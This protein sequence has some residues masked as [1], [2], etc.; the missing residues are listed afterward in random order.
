G[1]VDSDLLSI[2]HLAL[3]ELNVAHNSLVDI[4]PLYHLNGDLATLDISYNSIC[5]DGVDYDDG[6]ALYDFFPE[7]DA[8]SNPP[9][10]T[11]SSQDTSSCGFCSSSE[12]AGDGA[13][14]GAGDPVIHCSDTSSAASLSSNT[15]CRK[16]WDWTETVEGADDGSGGVTTT[17]TT[18]HEQWSVECNLY[19]YKVDNGDEASSSC[20][21]YLDESD[22]YTPPDTF[23][24]CVESSMDNLN[25][26]CSD[27]TGSDISCIEGWYSIMSTDEFCIYECPSQ[28]N[29][30][31][32]LPCGG[33]EYGTCDVASHVCTCENSYTGDSCQYVN[34]TSS[35]LELSIC[36][37]DEIDCSGSD[38]H[39]TLSVLSSVT[40]LDLSDVSLVSEDDEYSIS[41][42]LD[43]LRFATSL[44]ELDL[45]VSEFTVGLTYDLS[46]LSELSSL[47]TLNLSGNDMSSTAE[48][49]CESNL[50]ALPSSLTTLILDNVGLEE[51]DADFSGFS[52]LA[53]L[54]VRDN[55]TFNP[56]DDEEFTASSR[57]PTSLQNL[58]IGGCSEISDISF[59]PT[60]LTT[61]VADGCSLDETTDF[62]AF[63]SLTTLGVSDNLDYDV[64]NEVCLPESV[65]SFYAANTS[66]SQIDEISIM[67]PNVVNLD[68]SDNSIS[69]PS[70]LFSLSSTLT[71]LDLSGNNICGISDVED[72]NTFVDAFSSL[73]TNAFSVF[74]N[75]KCLC[76]D[77]T[78]S[79]ISLSSNIVCSEIWTDEYSATCCSSCYTDV[80]SSSLSC[81]LIDDE[82][83]DLY[84]TCSDLSLS[85]TNQK[86][87]GIGSD[88]SI[89]DIS[90]VCSEGWYGDDCLSECPVDEYGYECGNADG[91]DNNPCDSETHTCT[92]SS[93]SSSLL[94]TGDLCEIESG[95]TLLSSLGMDVALVEAIC[96]SMYVDD[97][98]VQSLCSSS[99]AE[100]ILSSLTVDDLSTITSLT[101]PTTVSSLSGLE[102]AEHLEILSFAQGNILISDLSPIAS[103]S[104]L[105][106]LELDSLENMDVSL[107]STLTDDVGALKMDLESD[108]SRWNGT[109]ESYC[110]GLCSLRKLRI[111]GLDNDVGVDSSSHSA[112][113]SFVKVEASSFILDSSFT[114][115]LNNL[116][117]CSGQCVSSD[118]DGTK[119]YPLS[120]TLT[121]L[122][123]SSNDISDPTIVSLQPG[124]SGVTHLTLSDNSISDLVLLQQ[125]ID[126]LGNVAYVDVSDNRLDCGSTVSDCTELLNNLCDRD[127]Y[128]TSSFSAVDFGSGDVLG[129]VSQDTTSACGS[130]SSSSSSSSSDSCSY[131]EDHRVCGVDYSVDDVDDTELACICGSGYYE[132]ISSGECVLASSSPSSSSSSSSACSNCGGERGTCVYDADS[133]SG[134]ESSPLFCE[135][136]DGW[137]GTDCSSICPVSD[138]LGLC[139]GSSHGT[140]DA[141]THTCVCESGYYGSACNLYCDSLSRC[142]LHGQCAVDLFSDY[143]SETLYCECDAGWYGSICSYKYPV[144]TAN[145]VDYVCGI[146]YS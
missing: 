131:L 63:L 118:D 50:A 121:H 76:D 60:Y 43:G 79:S 81:V 122:D 73:S 58:N 80:S 64:T 70:P 96:E 26:E 21:S 14:D 89:S 98:D 133:D 11:S 31:I 10:I 18:S 85:G 88:G 55:P 92:C 95:V 102:Y 83:T 69:D 19:S 116:S 104:S 54:S 84:V 97:A 32:L 30:G 66:I 1:L 40:K 28:E 109:S 74:T 140:C 25:A 143:S 9:S 34:F 90:L 15:I 52:Q 16:V 91:T 128:D 27:L 57:F 115:L 94:M 48:P 61:L 20:V 39:L 132:D 7:A 5:L 3:D 45:S 22:N 108:T 33:E 117:M 86:C 35:M 2:V 112:F 17:T 38:G 135:C 36:N 46:E 41:D 144:E 62:S 77:S 124:F 130:D 137:Y 75:N 13:G 8:S 107:L 59:V 51:T 134:D 129:S 103:L 23:P 114:S 65:T 119:V 138:D 101:I 110:V 82:D 24:T 56:E 37:L 71:T 126:G 105:Y 125:A 6:S 42:A 146:N 93:S 4:S 111:S 141:A 29:E 142:G 100:N 145:S 136:S 68:L 44:E 78:S 47:K 49:S 106:V 120:S 99:A 12:T 53:T 127:L 72:V 123:L 139:S 113:D 67:L 87:I